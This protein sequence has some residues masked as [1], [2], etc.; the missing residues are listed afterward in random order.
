MSKYLF[1]VAKVWEREGHVI[2]ISEAPALGIDYRFN[3]VLELRRPDGSS[4]EVKS[5]TLIVDSKLPEPPLFVSLPG[6]KAVDVPIGTQVW[7]VNTER[8]TRKGHRKFEPIERR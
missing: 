6:L 8:P 4:Q 3:D 5:E 1:T 2:V 7:L